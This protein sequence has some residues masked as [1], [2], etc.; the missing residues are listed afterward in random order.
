MAC[1]QVA[2]LALA[3]HTAA[4]RTV[5]EATLHQQ[6]DMPGISRS[7]AAAIAGMAAL[8]AGSSASRW[9]TWIRRSPISLP[10]AAGTARPTTPTE[11]PTSF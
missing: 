9:T 4:A 5:A 7:V 10:T 1:F 11:C 3:G 8:Y 2:A 6:A